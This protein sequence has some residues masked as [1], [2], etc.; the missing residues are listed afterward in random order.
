MTKPF[1][2]TGELAARLRV[3]QRTTPAEIYE[4]TLRQGGL[5]VDLVRHRVLV[6][7]NRLNLTMTEEALLHALVV[8]VGKVVSSRHLLRSVWGA[9]AEG[10]LQYLRSFVS[11][12]RKKLA[13]ISD[14]PVIE[15]VA[16]FGY[17]LIGRHEFQGRCI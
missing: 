1:D 8:H 10:E 17:R 15:T 6:N 3:L 4:P 13:S 11:C 7:G 9:K 12:L 16:H 2:G 14:A 5:N